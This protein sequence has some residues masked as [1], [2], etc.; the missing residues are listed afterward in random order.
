MEETEKAIAFLRSFWI[1]ALHKTR[2]VISG[3][4]VEKT[5]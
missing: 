4:K 2:P 5:A 1:S 3:G